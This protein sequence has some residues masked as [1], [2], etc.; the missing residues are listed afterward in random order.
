MAEAW[1]E[2]DSSFLLII[3]WAP[4]PPEA[5]Q[6]NPSSV[7]T[8]VSWSTQKAEVEWIFWLDQIEQVY[9]GGQC[10]SICTRNSDFADLCSVWSTVDTGK[11]WLDVTWL[12][13]HYSAASLSLTDPK[14][15][16]LQYL[17]DTVWMMRGHGF[18]CGGVAWEVLVIATPP[19][20]SPSVSPAHHKQ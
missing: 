1:V 18:L 17:Y 6:A 14:S 9:Q 12:V 15:F 11:V 2:Q 4:L 3:G 20:R 7:Q 5:L 8:L 19:V 10:V 13:L 16:L